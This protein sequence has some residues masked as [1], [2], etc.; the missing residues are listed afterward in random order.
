MGIDWEERAKLMK[1]HREATRRRIGN[2]TDLGTQRQHI[3]KS[4]RPLCRIRSERICLWV[5]FPSRQPLQ[6]IIVIDL[7]DLVPLIEQSRSR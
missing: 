2:G 6:V 4:S 1:A 3:R 5:R 7:G